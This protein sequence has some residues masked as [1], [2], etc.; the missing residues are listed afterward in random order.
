MSQQPGTKS[1]VAGGALG[2]LAICAPVVMY[3]EGYVPNGYADPV[4]I[5]TICYGH[6]GP[7]VRV[8]DTRTMAECEALLQGDL[9]AS[10]AAVRACIKHPLRDHE[11]AALTSFTYNVGKA[12]MCR[13]TLARKANAGNMKG[14]CAELSRW[15]YAKG[16]KFNGLVRRRAAERAMCEGKIQ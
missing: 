12:A 7:E 15:V 16:I 8:H 3:F 10:Y 2:V 14:A 4:G 6:T 5:P 9:A 11:A 1:I 13:S